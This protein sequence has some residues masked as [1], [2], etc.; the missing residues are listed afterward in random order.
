[1]LLAVASLNTFASQSFP[2]LLFDL[3]DAN[4]PKTARAFLAQIQT[5]KE[6]GSQ[7]LLFDSM[8]HQSITDDIDKERVNTLDV[9]S[10]LEKAKELSPN[11]PVTLTALAKQYSLIYDSKDAEINISLA[12]D[13][14]PLSIDH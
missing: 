7:Y 6:Y 9:I 8:F 4:S 2:S 14:D 5:T 10:R 11:N 1:M 3:V 12:S 13:I